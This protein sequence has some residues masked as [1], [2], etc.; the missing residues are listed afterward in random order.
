MLNVIVYPA[1]LLSS[2]S[3]LL[4]CAFTQLPKTKIS[5]RIYPT[6]YV[7][8][9][10]Q[11]GRNWATTLRVFQ[12]LLYTGRDSGWGHPFQGGEPTVRPQ[13]VVAVNKEYQGY[14]IY[15]NSTILF[16]NPQDCRLIVQFTFFKAHTQDLVGSYGFNLHLY[17]LF[18]LKIITFF[19]GSSLTTGCPPRSLCTFSDAG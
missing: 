15:P 12:G 4:H 19:Y 9:W 7:G 14:I 3:T 5:S 10:M 18:W 13:S 8:L 1:R 17:V 6:F 16:F 11:E 2:V